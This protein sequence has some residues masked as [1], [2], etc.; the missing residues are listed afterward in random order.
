MVKLRMAR[1]E[2]LRELVLKEAPLR[3]GGIRAAAKC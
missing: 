1:P 3:K 2:R